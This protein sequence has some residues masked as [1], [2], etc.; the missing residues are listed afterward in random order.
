MRDDR[1]DSKTAADPW[2]DLVIAILSVNNYPLDKTFALFESLKENGLL[3][4]TALA[5]V[6]PA[7]VA[8]RLGSAGYNRGDTMTA[9]F[10][11]RLVSLG[12]LTSDVPIDVCNSILSS[13]TR[14][15][16]SSLLSSV[17]GVGPKVLNNFFVLRD[18]S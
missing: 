6:G 5:A 8:Q 7:D 14:D 1:D 13:G 11:D 4:P 17:K 18:G 12:R 16:V 10:T 15:E 2:A 3:D 9:I